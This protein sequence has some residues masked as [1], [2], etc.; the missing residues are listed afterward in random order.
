VIG[1]WGLALVSTGFALVLIE[2]G[3]RIF[4]PFPYYSQQQI[5]HTE[6]GNLSEFDALLGWKGV[7]SAREFFVTNNAKI[8][9]EHNALGHRDIDPAQRD[10][11]R[12]ALVFLG[13]SFTWGYEVEADEMFVTILRERLP[14]LEIYNLAHRGYGT[15]QTYLSFRQWKERRTIRFAILMFTE[16]DAW[17][18]NGDFRYEKHKPL[19]EVVDDRLVLT[20]VPV[21]KSERWTRPPSRGSS[22]QTLKSRLA[23]QLFRSHFL[24]DLNFRRKLLTRGADAPTTHLPDLELTGRLI[25]E[26]RDLVETRGGRLIV[27][28]IPSKRQFMGDPRYV[29]YQ[30]RIR[31]L[32][33]RLALDYLDLAP[34]FE[35]AWL[36]TYFRRGIHWNRHG[37]EV[38]ADAIYELIGN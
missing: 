26:L 3:Y 13:D 34:A 32:C 5:N 35:R 25:R 15:D 27:V 31:V 21:P 20:N 36:R 22:V 24:N 6:H 29:P 38:A 19:F 14:Q 37:H 17:E 9:L 7:P 28:A 4:D 8:W 18:S 33:E 11:N 23:R 16:N 2:A 30:D 12:P 1:K 10:P